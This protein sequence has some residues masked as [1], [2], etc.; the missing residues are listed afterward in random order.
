MRSR[1][2]RHHPENLNRGPRRLGRNRSRPDGLDLSGR[3]QHTVPV[4]D[5]VEEWLRGTIVRDSNNRRNVSQFPRRTLNSTKFA[6]LADRTEAD[7]NL[8]KF[9][10]S[11]SCHVAKFD[12]S[13]KNQRS[14]ALSPLVELPQH[15]GSSIS[16]IRPLRGLEPPKVRHDESGSR[17]DTKGSRSMELLSVTSS[18]NR[19]SGVHKYSKTQR[20]KT[21][22]ER[23]DPAS[24]RKAKDRREYR[25][26]RSKIISSKEIMDTFESE[27]IRND[28]L[29]VGALVPPVRTRAQQSNR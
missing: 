2:Q 29:T 11:R 4:Q 27:A 28:R 22:E 6:V 20:H 16:S 3:L 13:H 14:S 17:S 10:P 5:Y 8:D 9:L 21:R 12:R 19:K 7:D 24:S 25:Q 23:Y 18:R 1:E 26:K 15:V